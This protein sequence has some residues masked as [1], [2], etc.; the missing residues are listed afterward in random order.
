M[1]Y[2]LNAFSPWEGYVVAFNGT[3]GR[4][5]HKCEEGAYINADGTIP[6]ALKREGTWIRVYPH[7]RPAYEVPVWEA[8][9]G[10]GG[11]D[12]LMLQHIFAP[13]RQPPDKYLRRADERSG[14]WSILTGAAANLSLAENRAMRIEELATDIGMPDYPPMPSPDEPLPGRPR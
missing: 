7:W 3:R 13:D 11:A 6:G 9:G 2:S 14:A 1:S 10:H 4:L 8:E 12:P 5:E